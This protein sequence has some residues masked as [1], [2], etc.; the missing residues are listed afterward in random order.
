MGGGRGSP[1]CTVPAVLRW[2]GWKQHVAR[3]THLQKEQC[4][5]NTCASTP[6]PPPR[7]SCPALPP[8]RHADQVRARPG[9]PVAHRPR[10]P[11]GAR[12]GGHAHAAE[13]AAGGGAAGA[14]LRRSYSRGVLWCWVETRTD[15]WAVLLRVPSDA[16]GRRGGLAGSVGSAG[17]F[18]AVL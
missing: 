10:V 2:R 11:G 7:A 13:A 8:Q 15:A 17:A 3:G 12:G 18:G 1:P 6:P 14:G 9:P 5:Y 4:P 16:L